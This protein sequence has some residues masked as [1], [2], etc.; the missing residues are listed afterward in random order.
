[1]EKPGKAMTVTGCV[2]TATEAGH[3]MLKDGMMTGDKMGQTYDLEGGDMKAHVGQ[4]SDHRYRRGRDRGRQDDDKGTDGQHAQH[5]AC[6]VHEDD[7]GKLLVRT[8][9]GRADTPTPSL[10]RL[11]TMFGLERG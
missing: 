3:Y 9:P 8:R 11:S 6:P 4:S 1:M 7:C 5:A 10:C 2:A